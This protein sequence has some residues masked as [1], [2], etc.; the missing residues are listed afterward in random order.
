LKEVWNII[1][2]K[3]I[4]ID[5]PIQRTLRNSNWWLVKF[6]KIKIIKKP[7]PFKKYTPVQYNTIQPRSRNKI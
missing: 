4:K 5:L 7:H 1:I 3:I 2:N 6:E